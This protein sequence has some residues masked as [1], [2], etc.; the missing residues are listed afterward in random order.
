MASKLTHV[1]FCELQASDCDGWDCNVCKQI[2]EAI[3]LAVKNFTASNSHCTPCPSCG[4]LGGL[5]NNDC[6]INN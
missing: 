2:F 3:E 6:T 4:C 1:K 5:H